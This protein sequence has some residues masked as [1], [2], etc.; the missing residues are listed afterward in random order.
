MVI[1]LTGPAGV[2]KTTV[3]ILL[4]EALG[5]DFLDADDFHTPE[6]IARMEAGQPLGDADRL[7]WLA[8]LAERIER[9]LADGRRVVIACSALKRRYRRMLTPADRAL[10]DRVRFVALWAHPQVL[11]ARLAERT[12]HFFSPALLA[13]QLAAVE[14]PG[15]SDPPLLA[16]DAD[17]APA[18]LVRRIREALDL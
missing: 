14:G 18:E 9:A 16:I 12:G 4:A 13:S 1:V 5:W 8:A 2:G 7:P 11:A 17:A 3:G 15:E 10:A 6:N